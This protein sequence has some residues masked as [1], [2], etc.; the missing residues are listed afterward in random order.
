[1]YR[2]GIDIGGTFTD[3]VALNEE[4]GEILSIKL[5]STPRDP[6]RGVVVGFDELLKRVPGGEIRLF[7]HATTLAA[8]ALLGQ[9]GL[10]IPKLALLVTKG[11][12]DVLEIGRQ[13]RSELYNLFFSKLRPLVPRRLRL[14]VDERVGPDGRVEKPVNEHE[15]RAI[16]EQLEREGVKSMAICF[17]NSYLNPVNEERARELVRKHLRGVLVSTSSDIFPEHREYERMTTTVVNAALMRVVSSYVERLSFAL[18]ERAPRSALYLMQSSG[19]MVPAPIACSK[20]TLIVESGPTAGVVATAFYG[21]LLGLGDLLSFDMGGTTAKAGCVKGGAPELTPEYE[22]GGRVHRGR[23]VKGSGYPVRFPFVDLAECSAGGGTIA[24]ADGALGVGP[25]SAGADPGPACYGAG[26]EEPT[27]TDANVV[28]GRLNPNYLLGG[29][30]RIQRELA[31]EAIRERLCK[32]LSMPVDEAAAGIIRLVNSEMSK[33]LRIVSV[34][35]GFDPRSFPIVAFGGAGPMHCCALAEDLG[36]REVIVP[37]SPGL[38]SAIGLL[39]SDVVRD[40]VRAYM[41]DVSEA[42]P[43]E[44]EGLFSELEER[45]ER[46]LAGVASAALLRLADVRYAG[47][48]YEL[49]V[50]ALKPFD[51]RGL[52][53]LVASFHRRHAEVYGFSAEEEEVTIVNLRVRAVGLI[54]KPKLKELP[55]S[56]REPP[57]GSLLEVRDVYFERPDSFMRT[58]VYVRERMESRNVVAG[59]AV[60]EQYDA[61]TVVYPGWEAEIDQYGNI[62]MRWL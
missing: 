7:V 57:P 8:N 22:V 46:E 54:E 37:P 48:A 4:T 5:P 3:L 19:G 56:G 42:A 21:G 62:V 41:R 58:P 25:M 10:E 24:W 36:V 20:P 59:P 52:G 35:R 31:V 51:G 43:Q 30:M 13:R 33:I 32:A 44:I 15:V 27:V 28:L 53:E 29:A 9:Y 2:V 6:A 60:I 55:P 1:V 34:E 23:L 11:F 38:F 17:L 39:F 40:F 18:R 49:T 47:Q 45:G 26:G 61:T 16:C 50:P 14:E 12:Q